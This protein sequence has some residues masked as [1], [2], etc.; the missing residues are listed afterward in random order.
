MEDDGELKRRGESSAASI[1]SRN[2]ASIESA[3]RFLYDED[4]PPAVNPANTQ[5]G[6]NSEF[7]GVPM[8]PS[9]DETKEKDRL[10]PLMAAFM[11]SMT[12]TWNTFKQT[13]PKHLLILAVGAAGIL[14]LVLIFT[15]GSTEKGEKIN[16]RNLKKIHGK[17]VAAGLSSEE[18]LGN[19]ESAQHNALSW[20]ANVDEGSLSDQFMLQRYA[21]A[22]LFYSTSGTLK[23][24]SP[25]GNWKKQT[26]WMSRK[27]Y[28]SWFGV[29][30]GSKDAD[31]EGNDQITKLTL[32]DNRLEGS[33][34]SELQALSNLIT[35]DFANNLLTST[36][37]AELLTITSLNY[38]LLGKNQLHGTLPETSWSFVGDLRELDLG[39]NQLHGTL[40]SKMF[41]LSDLRKLGLEHNEFAGEFTNDFVRF[42]RLSKFNYILSALLKPFGR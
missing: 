18:D 6:S 31:F 38:L 40:P 10:S 41:G 19:K 13:S 2:A 30:C 15:T 22:V 11:A 37:P 12:R 14:S 33:L 27:G 35:L 26:N 7:S 36:F 23:H 9:A 16:P 17:I 5:I 1:S 32:P 25:V 8:A 28:C 39:H 4:E 20:L 24:V 34:P 21:L 29:E 3:R 42:Q